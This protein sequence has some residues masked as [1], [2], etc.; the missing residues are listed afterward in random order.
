MHEIGFQFTGA[1]GSVARRVGV[2]TLVIAGWTGRD[3]EAVEKHIAE[4]EALGVQRP[5]TVPC[6]YRVSAARLTTA[7]SI[8][9][10]GSE[11]S[12]EVEFF[13]LALEDG[14]WV[15]VGSDHTDRKVEAYDVGVSKQMCAKPVGAEV[16]RF[17]DVA[18]HWDELI[19]R[20][21]IGNGG[22]TEDYQD[23]SVANML[24]PEELMSLY[25]GG[26]QGLAPGTLM[27][28]GTLAVI[29]GVRPAENF[30]GEL[31]DPVRGRRL[32]V[33][34]RIEALPAAG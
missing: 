33:N 18:D 20:S 3:R 17:S 24:P 22:S 25:A 9:V 19:L 32:T 30:S 28:C 16:W 13:L 5:E 10:L 31:L 23:G 4:L 8:Q 2:E 11:S 15:G 14:L 1:E 29:G 26:G 21:A 27:F 6:F 34:Y 12:G 7:A